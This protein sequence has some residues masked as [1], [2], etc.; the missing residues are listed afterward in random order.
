MSWQLARQHD[1]RDVVQNLARQ[2]LLADGLP[3][4][5]D[6]GWSVQRL[7]LFTEYL[8]VVHQDVEGL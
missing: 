6:R 4:R 7:A 8:V 3:D 5:V 1:V 2:I